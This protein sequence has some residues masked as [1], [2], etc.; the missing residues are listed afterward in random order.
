[1]IPVGIINESTVYSD[2]QT[3]ALVAALT[4]QANQ[5]FAP[6]Y[7]LGNI[8]LTIIPRTVNPLPAGTWILALLDNADQAGALGY[9][10]ITSD[11]LPLGK[12]FVKTAKQ[13]NDSPEVTASHELM[14]MLGDPDVNLT[15]QAGSIFIAYEVGDP[16]EADKFGYKIDDV[17]VSDFVLPAYFETFRKDRSTQFDYANHIIRPLQ[18]IDGGYQAYLDLHKLWLGWQQRFKADLQ[19]GFHRDSRAQRPIPGSRRE[20]RR[21]DRADWRTST[22]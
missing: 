8:D 3:K 14:E 16:V 2:D 22:R 19:T 1:M 12:V 13:Y 11:G 5:H 10:D 17:L 20:R 21:T 7:G 15:I 9:H 4:V 18:I 6:A